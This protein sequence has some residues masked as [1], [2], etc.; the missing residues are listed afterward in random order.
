MRNPKNSK[1][2]KML[3]LNAVAEPTYVKNHSLESMQEAVGGSIQMLACNDEMHVYC[4][5]EGML[6]GLNPSAYIPDFLRYL[7]FEGYLPNMVFGNVVITADDKGLPKGKTKMIREAY[8][9]WYIDLHKDV[10]EPSPSKRK[11]KKKRDE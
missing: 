4:N 11:R 9:T 10:E 6:K 8:R 1:K 7:G 2:E 3:K 5:E